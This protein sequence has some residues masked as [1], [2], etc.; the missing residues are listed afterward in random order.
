ML[1]LFLMVRTSG[2][3]TALHLNGCFLTPHHFFYLTSCMLLSVRLH[4]IPLFSALTFILNIPTIPAHVSA[5]L[6]TTKAPDIHPSL[7]TLLIPTKVTSNYTSSIS[8]HHAIHHH[9]HPRPRPHHRHQR[10]SLRFLLRQRLGC[11]QGP[12]LGSGRYLF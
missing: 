6:Y 9:R 10:A 11:L 4:I 5:L 2:Y 3:Y 8:H 7:S 1:M 12:V